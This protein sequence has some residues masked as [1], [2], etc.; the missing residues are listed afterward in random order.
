MF[1]LTGFD[2]AQAIKINALGEYHS[3]VAMGWMNFGTLEVQR[4]DYEKAL[5]FY[6]KALDVYEVT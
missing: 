6:T 4:E 5:E 3:D 1:Y 2:R